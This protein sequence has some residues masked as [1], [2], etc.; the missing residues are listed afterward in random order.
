MIGMLQRLGCGGRYSHVFAFTNDAA[1]GVMLRLFDK[2]IG[3]PPLRWLGD[4]RGLSLAH[5]FNIF[6]EPQGSS[7]SEA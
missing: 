1:G 7:C 3:P 5:K 4:R 6:Y 2:E